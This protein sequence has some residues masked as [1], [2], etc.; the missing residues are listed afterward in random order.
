[1]DNSTTSIS[2]RGTAPGSALS[3]VWKGDD[4]LP[5]TRAFQVNSV[6]GS[7]KHTKDSNRN[8][9][10]HH[11]TLH[12]HHVVKGWIGAP[13]HQ[14]GESRG[15][16]WNRQTGRCYST[17]HHPSPPINHL[18]EI[19]TNTSGQHTTTTSITWSESILHQPAYLLCYIANGSLSPQL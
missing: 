18:L 19:I 4:G 2:Q 16:W 12:H 9:T 8:S 13:I 3:S 10:E 17:H 15:L 11:A 5:S 14:R 1:M 7:V 6:A